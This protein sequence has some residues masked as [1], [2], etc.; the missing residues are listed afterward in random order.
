MYL[1]LQKDP[2]NVCAVHCL[3][4][5]CMHE[6][7]T[8]VAM[9]L[10]ER[11]Q[12]NVSQGALLA[13]VIALLAVVIAWVL[14]VT[15]KVLLAISQLH[16]SFSSCLWSFPN[17]AWSIGVPWSLAWYQVQV[18]PIFFFPKYSACNKLSND[19]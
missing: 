15:A 3:V 19:I 16:R 4:S 12:G 8:L 6:G 14:L 5:M 7:R 1:W 18:H 9:A 10:R 11:G 2:K 17:C 13:V